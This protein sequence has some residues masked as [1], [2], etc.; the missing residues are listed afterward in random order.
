MWRRVSL[1]IL[2]SSA[3]IVLALISRTS[4]ASQEVIELFRRSDPVHP[5]ICPAMP[6]DGVHPHTDAIHYPRGCG[7]N[8]AKAKDSA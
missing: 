2:I 7:S 4:A 8:P 6:V 5:L 1:V 3:A